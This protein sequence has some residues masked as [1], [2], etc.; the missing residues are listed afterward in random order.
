MNHRRYI[1]PYM[2][3]Y[4]S[5]AQVVFDTWRAAD[6]R[7]YNTFVLYCRIF[8]VSITVFCFKKCENMVRCRP[9]ILKDRYNNLGLPNNCQLSIVHCQFKKTVNCQLSTQT[10]YPAPVFTSLEYVHD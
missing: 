1:V 8:D 2:G 9:W 10:Q 6:C 5:P 4:H 3:A 7:P